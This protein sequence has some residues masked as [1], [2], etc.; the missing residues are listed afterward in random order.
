MATCIIPVSSHVRKI[1]TIAGIEYGLGKIGKS[2]FVM[3]M[4]AET[5]RS[6]TS[7][8]AFNWFVDTLIAAGERLED[9]DPDPTPISINVR[10]TTRVYA[11]AAPT[12]EHIIRIDYEAIRESHEAVQSE[13][14]IYSTPAPAVAPRTAH[15]A[16]NELRKLFLEKMSAEQFKT[17]RTELQLEIAE[18]EAAEKA[19]ERGP[20]RLEGEM[21]Y[22]ISVTEAV[23]QYQAKYKTRS[24]AAIKVNISKYD[25]TDI[26]DGQ[27]EGIEIERSGSVLPYHVWVGGK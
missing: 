25:H 11:V 9:E 13:L 17:R 20:V 27:L 12:T 15:E 6:F 21:Y 18:L 10:E 14:K 1:I 3:N 24:V 26:E 16:R 19:R 8:S 7:R 5:W 23:A 4:D 2:F 22:R